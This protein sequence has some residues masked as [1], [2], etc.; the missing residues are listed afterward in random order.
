MQAGRH[1]QGK[2]RDRRQTGGQT[3]RDPLIIDDNNNNN[4]GDKMLRYDVIYTKDYSKRKDSK[5]TIKNHLP[6][7]WQ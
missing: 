6:P 7:C 5:T 1:K 2:Q 4:D 3:D